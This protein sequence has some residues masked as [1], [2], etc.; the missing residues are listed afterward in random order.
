MSSD[1]VL[2]VLLGVALILGDMQASLEGAA[3]L[4]L[5]ALP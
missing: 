1:V 5:V 3:R 4:A 2:I